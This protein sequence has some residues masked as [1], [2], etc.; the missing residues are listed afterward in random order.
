MNSEVVA[1]DECLPIAVD[2]DA[3][4]VVGVGVGVGPTRHGGDDGIMM[5]QSW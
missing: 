1:A 5:C 2:R 4:D 3:V